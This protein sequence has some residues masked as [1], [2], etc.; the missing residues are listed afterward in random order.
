MSPPT[1]SRR[2]PVLDPAGPSTVDL[3][4]EERYTTV[5]KIFRHVYLDL[6]R[7]VGEQF[8]WEAIAQIA[9]DVLDETVPHAGD[10]YRRRFGLD[11]EGAALM[12]Q[13]FQIEYLAEG[14]D[15]AVAHE[16]TEA[17]EVAVECMWG[18]AIQRGEF[19][20]DSPMATVVCHDGCAGWAQ[21]VADG[22]APSL[23]VDRRE[24]MG[25]GAARCVF[26]FEQRAGE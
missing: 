17:A 5:V 8:G 13:V 24:W 4:L 26:V 11:A 7:R 10:G 21:R 2:F 6:V 9:A 22:I 16:S 14:S 3:S 19:A 15:V 12:S 23:E 20:P 18:D 25:D 1:P